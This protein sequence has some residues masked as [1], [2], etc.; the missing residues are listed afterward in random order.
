MVQVTEKFLIR[1]YRSKAGI[2]SIKQTTLPQLYSGSP[3]D[4]VCLCSTALGY[5]GELL[6]WHM[7]ATA[8]H[9]LV[10]ETAGLPVLWVLQSHQGATCIQGPA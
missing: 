2:S 1:S 10:L 5:Q 9:A 6:A 8:G 7:C 3:P 4:T